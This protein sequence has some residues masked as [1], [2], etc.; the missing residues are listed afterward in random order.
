MNELSKTI[1]QNER[2][3]SVIVDGVRSAATQ[4]KALCEEVAA[5]E[6]VYKCFL[7]NAWKRAF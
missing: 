4:L 1:N 6:G 7:S 2:G 3:K 5:R